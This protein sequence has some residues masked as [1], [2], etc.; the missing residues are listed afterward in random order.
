MTA[1]SER[2]L[3]ALGGARGQLGSLAREIW[4][5]SRRFLPVLSVT[6]VLFAA[7]SASQAG[8]FTRINIINLLTAASVLF[9][10][11]MG[12]TFVVLT[13][14]ADLSVAAMAALNG[15]FF[16]KIVSFG[17]PGWPAVILTLLLGLVL[18]GILNGLL[19][20]RLG[21]SF[22]VVTLA[23]MTGLTGVVNLW[24]GTLSFTVN[25]PAT[26][27]LGVNSYAGLPT[28]IWIMI[29]LFGLALYV[30]HFTFFGRDVFAVGGSLTAA[31]LSGI[32][33][34]RTYIAVYALAGVCAALGGLITIGRIGVAAP[35]VDPNLP[36]EAVASVLL[37]GTTLS[38][39]IGGVG[40]TAVGVLFI[41]IL[42]NGLSV[43][44]VPS[45]WQQVVTGVILILAVLGDRLTTRRLFRKKNTRI[46]PDEAGAPHSKSVSEG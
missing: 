37:G 20:G 17:I 33:V 35:N 44:G 21:L 23:S 40:G 19:V 13:A 26:L 7:L 30:Q 43:A 1:S 5:R 25:S 11:S 16:A 2:S 38:G 39:G 32:R 46:A 14:G 42:Q 41:G 24:S 22:F 18:G 45:F 12:M 9:V 34:T 8:F 4:T 3:P 15:I 36:L 28:P 29:V 27:E 10:V 31:R 6:V